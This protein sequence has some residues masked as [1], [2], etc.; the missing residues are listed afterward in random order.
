[1]KGSE[2]EIQPGPVQVEAMA[3]GRTTG[4]QPPQAATVHPSPP[5]HGTWE[6]AT[7]SHLKKGTQHHRQLVSTAREMTLTE[8]MQVMSIVNLHLASSLCREAQNLATFLL[9]KK[10]AEPEGALIV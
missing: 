8:M 5:G 7:M 6:R 3:W 1:M 10:T 2:A 4:W 9:S